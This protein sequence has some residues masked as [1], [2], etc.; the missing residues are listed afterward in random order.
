VDK[1]EKC[2]HG[3]RG[4]NYSCDNEAG[5][6]QF[7]VNHADSQQQAPKSKLSSLEAYHRGDATNEIPYFTLMRY[8]RSSGTVDLETEASI[9]GGAYSQATPI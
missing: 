9:Q 2:D 3:D 8:G 6:C 4:L 1:L 7:W 5:S